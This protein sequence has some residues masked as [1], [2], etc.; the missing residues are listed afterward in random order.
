MSRTF[1]ASSTQREV[2]QAHGHSGSNQ[3]STRAFSGALCTASVM[4]SPPS[5]SPGR[6]PGLLPGA[7][8][9]RLGPVVPGA[10]HADAQVPGIP[11]R[12]ALSY[13]RGRLPG[14]PVPNLT[15]DEAA[16]R[17]ELLTVHE[18]RPAARRHRRRRPP[19]ERTFRSTT[20]VR[21]DAA[22]PARARS[23]TWSPTRVRSATLNGVALD[24][25]ATP[26][27]AAWPLPDLAAENDAGGRRRLPLLPHRR[28][29]A[30]VRRP[31]GRRRSTSTRSSSRTTPT[32]C[33]PASTS[34]TSRPPSR[35][36]STAPLDW[37]VVSNTGG[38]TI[39]AGAGRLAAGALRAD[40]AHLDLHH[41]AGRRALPQGHRHPRRASPLGLYCRASLAEHLDADEIFARHQ[42]GLRLLP[43]GL[44]LPVPV[45]Q[46]RPALRARVQRRRDGER[47][48]RDVPGGLR[49]PVARSPTPATSAAPRRSCTSWRTCGSAT[50]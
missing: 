17:A 45:R 38:R 27:T 48:L 4:R 35:C 15:R 8:P 9:G 47:R 32:G 39:E 7:N 40:H 26:R 18:L 13:R 34:P 46:V 20:M 19:G 23:S 22:T 50:W 16:A 21:F 3:K 25:P 1:S 43:P 6:L 24:V 2:I 49:L 37:Q 31:G 10:P 5:R 12:A 28:G 14:V 29:P 30:P 33:T 41:R 42:A 36:T 44:R 11:R